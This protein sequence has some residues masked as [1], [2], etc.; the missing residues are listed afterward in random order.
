MVG[1]GEFATHFR[2]YFS[3]DG[4]VHWGYDLGFDPWHGK[5]GLG[6]GHGDGVPLGVAETQRVVHIEV[7]RLKAPRKAKRGA[8]EKGFI[9]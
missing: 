7:L 8:P 3:E 9:G 5:S 6:T 4:D 2:T 1:I